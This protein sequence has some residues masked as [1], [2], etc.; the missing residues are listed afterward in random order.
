MRH[1]TWRNDERMKSELL[2]FI[3]KEVFECNRKEATAKRLFPNLISVHRNF[4][5]KFCKF[6]NF[7]DFRKKLTNYYCIPKV[8]KY[9][10]DWRNNISNIEYSQYINW[11]FA[12]SIALL[13]REAKL[14]SFCEVKISN[15]RSTRVAS[16]WSLSKCIDKWNI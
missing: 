7:W 8:N 10:L 16:V 13:V 14:K 1:L 2:S 11:D 3:K 6:V 15:D 12:D 4:R 5:A 9:I